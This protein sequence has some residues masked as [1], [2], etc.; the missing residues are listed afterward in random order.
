MWRKA[1]SLEFMLLLINMFGKSNSPSDIF[2][3]E[4]KERSFDSDIFHMIWLKEKN[5]LWKA[6]KPRKIVCWPHN[7][8]CIAAV[9]AVSGMRNSFGNQIHSSFS[10]QSR[11]PRD[12]F[13]LQINKSVCLKCTSCQ[14]NFLHF[15]TYKYALQCPLHQYIICALFGC[16]QIALQ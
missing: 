6:L 13:F 4:E 1:L 7:N 5:P 8:C 10:W 3:R 2:V 12:N 9:R 16:M 15:P 11:T 14:L